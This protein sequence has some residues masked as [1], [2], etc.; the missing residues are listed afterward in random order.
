MQISA[1]AATKQVNI[2]L[3]TQDKAVISES[4]V[5]ARKHSL[6]LKSVSNRLEARQAF[7][8]SFFHIVLYDFETIAEESTFIQNT[9]NQRSYD[10]I[11]LVCIASQTDSVFKAERY[12]AGVDAVVQKPFS[13]LELDALLNLFLRRSYFLDAYGDII[14]KKNLTDENGSVVLCSSS[15]TI[16]DIQK[17]I[18][19]YPLFVVCNETELFEV[20]QKEKIW[21]IL[22]STKSVWA[23]D[24][25]PKI[26]N[27][28]IYDTQVL[29][30]RENN[31][32]D[33]EVVKF[34]NQGGDDILTIKKPAFILS[35]QINARIEREIQIK[36]KYLD[37]LTTT[38]KKLP[39]R[40][41]EE[42]SQEA[43]VWKFEVFHKANEG[44]PGG[45][46]YE[47]SNLGNQ[48][49]LL[50]MGDVMGKS[51]GAWYFSLA[52][53][54]YMRSL[55]KRLT[56]ENISDPGFFLTE[57]NQLI[58]RD[59]RLSEVFTTLNV[60]L[61]DEN[62]HSIKLAS[63]G[64]LPYY[65]FDSFQNFKAIKP[66]GTLLGVRE[67][68]TYETISIDFKAEET[69]MVCTDGYFEAQ[70]KT[71]SA[72]IKKDNI[73]SFFLKNQAS[74]SSSIKDL[75]Q[76]LAK[77]LLCNFIDD[78]TLMRITFLKSDTISF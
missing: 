23:A 49:R 21:L 34:F 11:A 8:E 37:A 35:R 10:R 6:N 57:L 4:L 46:F 25:L 33:A 75:D 18:L 52:Y 55:I 48:K 22:I 66:K 17:E 28:P 70:S 54:A 77:E 29:W 12:N 44:I 62:S 60:M 43:G 63:A 73:I 36:Q 5:F 59:L 40:F 67:H 3:V 31:V 26:K 78:R 42:S 71:D 14:S 58:Y 72:Y 50:I 13:S 74:C 19:D 39:I 69:L 27:H 2:L 9:R 53:L 7:S 45:D 20:L 61:L 41:K 15:K 47:L 32:L 56:K 68:E 64:A 16:L 38:A 51:W 65:I 76:L 1:Y 24:L 30:L